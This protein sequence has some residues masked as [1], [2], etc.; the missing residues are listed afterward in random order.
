VINPVEL[1]GHG[2]RKEREEKAEMRGRKETRW[3]YKA[4]QAPA[5]WLG[6]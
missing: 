6:I 5:G 3:T 4:R 2:G 1:S